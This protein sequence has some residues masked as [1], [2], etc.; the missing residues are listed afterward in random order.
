MNVLFQLV[1]EPWAQALGGSLLHF[2]W[3]GALLGGLAWAA[4]ALLRGASAKVRY[5]VAC[6]ALLLMAVLPVL[7]FLHLR[8]LPPA[9]PAPAP[10][11]LV[12]EAA[13][14]NPNPLA[15]H[16]QSLFEGGLPWLLVGWALGVAAL[17]LRFLG[18]WVGLQRLRHRNARP[19]PAEW[20]WSTAPL[21]C[22]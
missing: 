21:T 14:L 4:L 18:G 22:A 17:S 15:F 13:P 5:G 16:A 3:Q 9:A 8:A 2:L 11:R 6:A 1:R 12:V 20:A 7:T 10:M 19:V